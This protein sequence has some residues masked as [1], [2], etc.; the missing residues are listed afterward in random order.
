LIKADPTGVMF[1]DE[2]NVDYGVKHIDNKPRVS[3]MP[4]TYDIAE[5]NV[6]DH[7]IWSKMGYNAAVT[8]EE[9]ISPQGGT[10]VFPTAE[11]HMH[12]IGGAQDNAT[13]TGIQSL[14]IYYL[15]AAYE[16]K[17][18]D[19]VPTGATAAETSVS[20]IFRIQHF[21]AKTV[22]GSTG[23]AG[24]ISI[25][26]HAETITYGYIALGNTRARQAVWTVPKGKTLYVTDF[27]R[28]AVHTAVNKRTIVTLR[29]TYDD[30]AGVALTA[31][32][33]FM[34]YSE[35]ILENSTEDT[36]YELPLKFIQYTDL[37][38]VG[39]SDGTATVSCTLG[40]W[41]E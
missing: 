24:N 37:I 7:A 27:N 18:V 16:E 30:K 40:G 2:N 15:N 13:G 22:G 17:S 33:F 6:A 41:T 1:I 34:P 31:G 21:R 39:T 23:A 35:T 9:I 38:V 3:A 19:V 20:D 10:Y 28:G 5:G 4:Y 36:C 8:A 29:A 26:N 32:T 11:Q 12:V 14:T 25:K